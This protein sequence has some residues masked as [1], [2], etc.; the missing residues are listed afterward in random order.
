MDDE[1]RRAHAAAIQELMRR[2]PTRLSE[3]MPMHEYQAPAGYKVLAPSEP[4]DPFPV[5]LQRDGVWIVRI[6]YVCGAVVELETVGGE[7]VALRCNRP[8]VFDHATQEV[9]VAPVTLM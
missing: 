7:L 8:L 2:I 1:T 9:R 4:A 6:D 5:V 3:V